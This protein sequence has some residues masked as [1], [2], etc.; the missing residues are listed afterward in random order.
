MYCTLLAIIY[1]NVHF[2]DIKVMY[3]QIIGSHSDQL[4]N[5]HFYIN[6]TYTNIYVMHGVW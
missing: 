6:N 4:I 5:I 2:A 1:Q 3:I